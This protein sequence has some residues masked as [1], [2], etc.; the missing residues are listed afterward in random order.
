MLWFCGLMCLYFLNC[1]GCCWCLQLGGFRD[2]CDARYNCVC[3]LALCGRD[4]EAYALLSRLLASGGILASDLAADPD[5]GHVRDKPW[6]QE[7][8]ASASVV[9]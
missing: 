5:F 4:E 3:A 6:F 8:L 2:R 1:D 7:M 9:K